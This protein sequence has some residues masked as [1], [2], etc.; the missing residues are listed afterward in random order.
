MEFDIAH[1]RIRVKPETLML[2]K[3]R[4]IYEADD[5]PNKGLAT[6]ILTYVHIA[7]QIDE[8]APFFGAREDEIKELAK[9]NVWHGRECPFDLAMVDA[10]IDEYRKSKEVGE[11]RILKIFNRKIDQIQDRIDAVTPQI[12]EKTDA[13][14]NF[15]GFAS[16]M[17]MI[18]KV[19]A[20]LNPLLDEKDKLV[21][22][23]KKQS[24]AEKTFRAGKKQNLLE[25]RLL[26]NGQRSQEGGTQEG[27]E[28]SQ[29]NREIRPPTGPVEG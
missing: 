6:D 7:A 17:G 15:T 27:M 5:S 10:A 13:R 21:Q 28:G 18:T 23:M 11:M 20:E 26:Q 29:D 25:R 2:A 8:T 4:D 16:N 14:G 22:R 24:E 3:L 19:M 1:G 12:V 9:M